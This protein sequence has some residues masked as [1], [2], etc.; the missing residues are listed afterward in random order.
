M[1]GHRWGVVG[2]ALLAAAWS[3]GQEHVYLA[4][5]GTVIEGF[6]APLHEEI[7]A[8]AD[9]QIHTSDVG[10][11]MALPNVLEGRAQIGMRS[12]ELEEPPDGWGSELVGFDYIIG[13]V[14]ATDRVDFLV[15]E[16]NPV[17]GIPLARLQEVLYG[18]EREDGAFTWSV[19]GVTDPMI[20]GAEVLL[21][22]PRGLRN[23]ESG[24]RRF[25]ER[26]LAP[27]DGA[28][29]TASGQAGREGDNIKLIPRDVARTRNA[30]GLSSRAFVTPDIGVRPVSIV[31]DATGETVQMQRSLWFYVPARRGVALDESICRLLRCVGTR[32]RIQQIVSTAG[33]IPLP[34]G[35]R[36]EQAT[37]L[38]HVCSSGRENLPPGKRRHLGGVMVV[39]P[40]GVRRAGPPTP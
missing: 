40:A 31:D 3:C 18:A 8:C 21:F 34:T 22:L 15:H 11:G 6:V 32:E 29:F 38:D 37:I 19:L 14:A 2:I 16:S 10:S 13:I 25:A 24:T 1:T 23:Q 17:G 30:L 20:S 7:Q 4:G 5:S 12:A 36:Q 35:L 9:L 33:F 39:E 27:H 26:S 28:M